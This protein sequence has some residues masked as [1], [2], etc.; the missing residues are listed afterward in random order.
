M[1]RT[2]KFRAWDGKEMIYINDLYWFEENHV[3][4]VVDGKAD[5]FYESFDVMQFTGLLDKNGK[6]IYEGDIVSLDHGGTKW[7]LSALEVI[8]LNGSFQFNRKELP[9]PCGFVTYSEQCANRGLLD[10]HSDLGNIITVI[11]NIHENPDL[12]K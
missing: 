9:Y 10:R 1:S 2:I 11:G 7:D 12:L 4:E 5:G 3:R 8:F 6:E